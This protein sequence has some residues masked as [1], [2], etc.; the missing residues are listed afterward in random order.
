MPIT[1]KKARNVFKAWWLLA[2]TFVLKEAL[3]T[4]R[5]HKKTVCLEIICLCHIEWNLSSCLGEGNICKSRGLDLM[6]ILLLTQ[7]EHRK[8]MTVFIHLFP[9]LIPV[10][11]Y[12]HNQTS[13]P[14]K[15]NTYWQHKWCLLRNKSHG[16]Q[17]RLIPSGL[18]LVWKPG[19]K[20][21]IHMPDNN[22]AVLSC[23]LRSSPHWM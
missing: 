13:P 5:K 21:Y 9:G 8:S 7:Y 1:F 10:C 16:D 12:M 4:S 11:L 17:P 19:L 14:P 18:M 2:D 22:N 15:K 23:L 6:P 3:M 20:S